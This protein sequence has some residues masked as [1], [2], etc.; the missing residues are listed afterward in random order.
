MPRALLTAENLNRQA[1]L[2]LG[3]ELEDLMDLILNRDR[4]LSQLVIVQGLSD[5]AFDLYCNPGDT[6]E[7]MQA[8][9][10]SDVEMIKPEILKTCGSR[11]NFNLAIAAYIRAAAENHRRTVRRRRAR[12]PAA[13]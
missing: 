1:L 6:F 3:I 5:L 10:P 11:D 4:R 8:F 7:G 12:I 13:P 9:L 2:S